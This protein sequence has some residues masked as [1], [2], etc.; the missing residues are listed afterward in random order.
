MPIR[1]TSIYYTALLK[2]FIKKHAPL[3][4]FLS[5]MRLEFACFRWH[6]LTSLLTMFYVLLNSCVR[7]MV[8][9]GENRRDSGAAERLLA[10]ICSVF[11]VLCGN[12]L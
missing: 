8:N 11:Q 5:L 7:I 2:I 12:D 1:Q 3:C 4:V 9:A 10:S 6:M